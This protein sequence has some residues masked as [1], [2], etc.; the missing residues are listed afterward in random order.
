MT[1]RSSMRC[2]LLIPAMIVACGVVAVA[3][4]PTYKL[5]RSP[6]SEE[7]R[8]SDATIGPDGAELPP[9]SGTAVQGAMTFAG[10]GCQGCHGPTGAE[11][12][13]PHLVGPRAAGTSHGD[14]HEGTWPGRGIANFPFAP[15]IWSWINQAMPLNQHGFLT[16]DEVYR[17]TAYVLYRND[18]IQ[19]DDVMDAKSL[20]QVRMPKRDTYAPPPF[21]EWKPGLRQAQGK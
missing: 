1:G 2:R 15:L 5:G 12:P 21:S 17:L 16:P 9:G 19:E 8:P 3:Q 4:A 14:E 13:A 11:G 6:T 10:R 20:P 18:I 7:L